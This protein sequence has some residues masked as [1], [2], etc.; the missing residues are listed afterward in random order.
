MRITIL[1]RPPLKPSPSKVS[2]YVHLESYPSGCSGPK[3][4]SHLWFSSLSYTLQLTSRNSYWLYHEIYPE[5]PQCPH[6]AFPLWSPL[7]YFRNLGLINYSPWA[8][9]GLLPFLF[10]LFFWYTIN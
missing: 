1:S 3:P 10:L 6:V 2:I 5:S 7:D 9:S 4:W 8:K